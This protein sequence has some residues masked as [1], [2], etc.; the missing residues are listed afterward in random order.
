MIVFC[1]VAWCRIS[2]KPVIVRLFQLFLKF[3]VICH[4]PMHVVSAT[5]GDFMSNPPYFRNDFI[6]HL[7]CLHLNSLAAWKSTASVLGMVVSM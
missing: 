1:A 2:G 3:A 4:D 7:H 5:A 6:R